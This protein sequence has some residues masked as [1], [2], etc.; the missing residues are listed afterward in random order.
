ME[1]NNQRYKGNAME[2]TSF[3]QMLLENLDIHMPKFE[4]NYLPH[5]TK[6]R[7]KLIKDLNVKL[8]TFYK[9]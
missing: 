4:P 8:H 2:K 7:P 5:H 9:T 3:Q 1:Q 6:I